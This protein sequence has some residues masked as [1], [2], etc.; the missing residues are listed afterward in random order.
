MLKRIFAPFLLGLAAALL[1]GC[2][3][4]AP[5]LDQAADAA[6]KLV[7]FY[8]DNVTSPEVRQQFREAV[9]AK[10]APHAVNVTC[11]NGGPSLQ[12]S[13]EGSYHDEFSYPGRGD[14]PYG[15]RVSGPIEISAQA[16]TT[17]RGRPGVYLGRP[18]E[19]SGGRS[20]RSEADGAG[21]GG[22]SPRTAEC[23]PGQTAGRGSGA[24]EAQTAEPV[25]GSA[26]ESGD[27]I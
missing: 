13:L 5:Q 25:A 6:G 24:R 23:G 10:A 18:G 14:S 16:S 26:A 7:K 11:A 21:I 17:S 3:L 15:Y 12:S 22:G 20:E 1:S 2:Q 9:N 8:C 4:L 27:V 19:C